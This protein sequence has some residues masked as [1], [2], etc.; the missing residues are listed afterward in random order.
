MS[1]I[2]AHQTK[3][4]SADVDSQLAEAFRLCEST[5][6]STKWKLTKQ[7]DDIKVFTAYSPACP[8]FTMVYSIEVEASLEEWAH[9]SHNDAMLDK[10]AEWDKTFLEGQILEKMTIEHEGQQIPGFY[11]RWCFDA[12]PMKARELLYVSLLKRIT[13]KQIICCYFSIEDEARPCPSKYVR[14]FN[15]SPSFDRA[16]DLGNGKLV[17]DHCMT[18]NLG[19]SL[20]NWVWNNLFH[21]A[22]ASA[23]VKEAK[24]LRDQLNKSM[25]KE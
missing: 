25:T 11:L 2:L 1:S 7:Q 9:F 18:T 6:D 15:W 22:V 17:I 23:Y 13:E 8:V 24:H 3:A 5:M 16:T 10:S 19:G 20:P 14:A 12:G 21:G 4:S